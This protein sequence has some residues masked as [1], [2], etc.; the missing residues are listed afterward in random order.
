MYAADKLALKNV[1][2]KEVVVQQLT[3]TLKIYAAC[4][5]LSDLRRVRNGPVL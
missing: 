4:T 3:A 5:K 2:N 1:I